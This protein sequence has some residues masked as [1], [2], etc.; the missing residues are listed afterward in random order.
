MF[1]DPLHEEFGTWALGFAPYGGA[2]VGEV[3]AIAA[4]VGDGDDDAFYNAWRAA[5]DRLAG[6]GKDAENAGH[7]ASAREYYLHAACFYAVAYHPIYGV[8]VD[9]RLVDGF[10]AQITAFDA[11]MR[12]TFPPIEAVSIPYEHTTMPA[13]LIRARGHASERRPLLIGTNGY[14][15]TVTEMYFAF[16]V[17][18]A[19][20][21]YHC[22]FFDGPG[23]GRLLIDEGMP[24]RADWEHVVTPVVDYALDLDGVD[25][26]RIALTGW[27]L[28]GYLALRA[29]TAEHRLA[30]CIADPG[31]DGIW[32]GILSMAKLGGL[33]PDAIDALPDADDATL[34]VLM[35]G[36]EAEP[37]A[38]WGVLKRGFWVNGADNLGDWLKAVEPFA[39]GDRAGDIRCPTLLT[40]AE[41]DVLG[42]GAPALLARLTCPKTLLEFTAAEGAGDH[43]EMQNRSL[44]NRRVFDWLD[45]VLGA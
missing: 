20:R 24:L 35:Q 23:Q 40:S 41:N 14:D 27:S 4:T 22:L 26:D 33:P 43:C 6:E 17:A 37:H 15:A 30:A 11:A 31:F 39:L 29:A 2:D 44:L 38:K 7:T 45:G 1:K 9:P 10:N 21:G 13:Y 18:A 3:A 19:D 5:A 42:K 25:H 28:G 16:A 36:I 32:S 34:R 12:L 8:P